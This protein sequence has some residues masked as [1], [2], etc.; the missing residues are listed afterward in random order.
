M[1]KTAENNNHNKKTLRVI[2]SGGGKFIS[3]AYCCPPFP[4]HLHLAP[5]PSYLLFL[6]L[7]EKTVNR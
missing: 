4:L 5:C 2:I 3:P 1:N 6:A 7:S